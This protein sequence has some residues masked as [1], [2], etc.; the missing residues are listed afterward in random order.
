MS[1]KALSRRLPAPTFSLR[2]NS[3][4]MVDSA[5]CKICVVKAHHIIIK[6]LTTSKRRDLMA[7]VTFRH[8]FAPNLEVQKSH[9]L[10]KGISYVISVTILVSCLRDLESHFLYFSAKIPRKKQNYSFP[11]ARAR[12]A[13]GADAVASGMEKVVL[14]EDGQVRYL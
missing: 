5:C 4:L 6:G 2:R 13:D 1:S 14:G 10:R 12:M 9:P 3:V 11:T 8:E 7:V